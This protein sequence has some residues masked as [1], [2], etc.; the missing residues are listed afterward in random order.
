MPVEIPEDL[1][2]EVPEEIKREFEKVVEEPDV[3]KIAISS[4]MTIDGQYEESW[5]LATDQWVV[6]ITPN[7]EK[8]AV[9]Q[10]PL[11][12]VV[13]VK[14]RNYI[15]NGM[16]ELHTAEKAV[17]VLRYSKTLSSKVSDVAGIL[18][19]LSGDG[20]KEGK[21]WSGRKKR[22]G[23]CEKCGSVLHHWSGTCPNCLETRRM[24]FRLLSYLKP[25]WHLAVIV[26]IITIV[27]T[28]LGLLPT[29]ITRP[30]T[31][32]V[33]APIAPTTPEARFRLLNLLVLAL[34]GIYVLNTGIGAVQNYIS[35]WMGT[36]VIYDLRTQA[37]EHLQKLSL[38]FYSKSETGRLIARI[39]EDTS[40]LQWFIT[41][42]LREIIMD[43]L[44]IV[45][46][47]GVLFYL[48]WKLAAITLIPL[49][50]LIIGAGYFGH[51]M[52]RLFHRLWRRMATITAI[53]ADTIPGVKVVKAFAAE[54]REIDRFNVASKDIFDHSIRVAKLTMIYYPIMGFATFA[55][56][57]IVRWVGG[58]QIIDGALTLGTLMVFMGYMMRFYSPIQGLTRVNERFQRAAAAAERIFEILDATPEIVETKSSVALPNLQGRIKF[59]N[60]TFS[61][62]GEK[63]ALEDVSFEVE[64]G[65]MIGLSGPSG[66]GKS[67]LVAL[68]CRFYDVTNGS[69]YIDGHDIRDIKLHSLREQIGVVLQEPFLFHGSIAENVAYGNP[70]ATREEIIAAANAANAHD[71]IVEFPDGY[72]SQ[73]GER[74]VKLSGGERQRI[75]IAR[76]ILKN[77]K[78]LIL[79]EATSSVDTETEATIQ[80][81]IERLVQGRTTF[82]IAHRL[83]TLRR[84]NRLIILDKGDL[85]DM[86]THEELLSREGLYK[87]LVNMQSSLS[88]IVAIGR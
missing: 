55:G 73:V 47:C 40:R 14:T 29:Y 62:D 27:T 23:R 33:F 49:P 39:G 12:D 78:I 10:M 28:G 60:V 84:A 74:G 46:M 88:R 45:G 87:R 52:H 3:V 9:I 36:S 26:G 11:S 67:T 79:D 54:E 5:L 2:E 32:Q 56:G 35:R 24:M 6:N 75:S 53:L 76:A 16:L 34:I 69:I 77:P 13:S 1:R 65:E 51:K 8:A 82:A 7:H 44:M 57:I 68:V 20:T 81:A 15:G 30:L 71:F 21:K 18:E 66:A 83:S 72:D 38:S 42:S 64:P 50:V 25:Y 80:E 31:D 85:E 48:N 4:D 61:Y 63:N 17:P 43:I 59:E 58:G 19:T 41:D 86:G 70:K 37:Y 22:E